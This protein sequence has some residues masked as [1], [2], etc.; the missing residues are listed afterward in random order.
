LTLASFAYMR[1]P[2]VVAGIAFFIGAVS[3]W[4]R[5][6]LGAAI[7]MML[8]A[9]AARM[10]LVVLD[11]FLT[12]QPLAAAL[13]GVPPGKLILDNQ[14][15]TFSSAIFYANNYRSEKV[16]LLN[17]RI[18]NLEYGSYA[19]DAPQDIF[20]DDVQFR[21]RWLSN[22]LYYICVEKEAVSRLEALVGQQKLHK[23]TE[24][25][26]KLVFANRT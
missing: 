14:Y 2:L 1:A 16:F 25:G 26:G 15:Y 18:N 8:F 4:R 24:S 20:I 17:G 6:L 11:P 5:H 13:N 23:I 22:D 19:P 21:D 7:M 10:A 9:H 3:A 12:S